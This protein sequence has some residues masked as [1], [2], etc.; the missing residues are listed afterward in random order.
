MKEPVKVFDVQKVS[1]EA[2]NFA[3]DLQNKGYQVRIEEY[4]F[5]DLYQVVFK[6]RKDI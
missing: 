5:E 4:D 2:K 1:L 3:Q 6:V